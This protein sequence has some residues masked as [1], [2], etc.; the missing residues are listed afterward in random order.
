MFCIPSLH[1]SSGMIVTRAAFGPGAGG[2]VPGRGG[3]VGEPLLSARGRACGVY[4][5]FLTQLHPQ[6]TQVVLTNPPAAFLGQYATGEVWWGVVVALMLAV[7]SVAIGAR[8]FRRE[9]V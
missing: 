3:V 6:T 8:T 4:R 5:Q 7:L 1:F 9:N 2:R